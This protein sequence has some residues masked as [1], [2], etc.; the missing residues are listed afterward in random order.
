M[1]GRLSILVI[2]AAL[3][4]GLWYFFAP[5]DTPDVTQSDTDEPVSGAAP[6]VDD[7]ETADT[8][9][10]PAADTAQTKEADADST[11]DRAQVAD[12]DTDVTT[13]AAQAT[14]P[15]TTI[16]AG[17]TQTADSGADSTT[18]VAQTPESGATPPAGDTQTADSGADSTTGVAQTP[19]SGAT[20]PAGDTQTA[21]SEADSTTGVAQT[22]ESGATPPAG[23][24]QTADSVA[25]SSTDAAQ[26][27]ASGATPKAGDTQTA[28]SGADS[29]TD[30]AQTSE[31]DA[32]VASDVAQTAGTGLV[33]PVDASGTPGPG[34]DETGPQ[35][36]AEKVVLAPA[37]EGTIE[38][39]PIA[40][41]DA[42][43]EDETDRPDVLAAVADGIDRL[44]TAIQDRLGI[45]PEEDTDTTLH[46][47]IEYDDTRQDPA[48]AGLVPDEGPETAAVDAAP[49]ADV[50]QTTDTEVA[51]DVAQTAGTGLV[52]EEGPETAAVDATPPADV[53]QTTDT[54]VASDVAQTA[55]TGLVPEEGPE[56]A[57][58]DATP[59]A[60][61]AQ[62]TDTEVASDVAQTAGTGLV[63]PVD[64]AGTPGSGTVGTGPQDTAMEAD[65]SDKR[66]VVLAPAAEGTIERTPIAPVD[67]TPEDETDRPDV[68]VAVADGID[69]LKTAI[70]N[71]LGI[72]PGEDTD[73][74]LRLRIEYDDTKQ[75]PAPTGLGPDE[76]SETADDD[77]APPPDVAPTTDT[78]TELAAGDAA[79]A[80]DL[81]QTTDAGT[82]PP[83]G[84]AQA[85]GSDGTT[86]TTPL[87]TAD[88]GT[89]PPPKV[90][91]TARADASGEETTGAE[92]KE[93][94]ETL[95][96]T[97]PPTIPVDK[98]DH[99]VTQDSVVSLVPEDS[100]ESITV[101]DL[102][103][104]E[105]LTPETPITV[106]REVE[107]IETA[108]P[109]QLIA[110]S[111]GNLDTP[112]R[113]VVTY[114]D[115][116]QIDEQSSTEEDVAEQ[117]E[118][119]RNV[120]TEDTSEQSPTTQNVVTEDTSG[121]SGVEQITVREALARMRT[122]PEK[123]LT[124]IKTVRYFEV[125][126]LRE[127]LD[128]EKD[129]DA[130][131]NVV[132]QPYRIE[133]ATLADLLRLHKTQ[134]PD[135]I[136]YIHTV[137]PT[138]EQGIWGIVHFG[139][140]E[141]FARGMAVRRGEEIETYTV[142]IPKHADE[143][144]DDQSSSFLGRLIDR[145]TKDSYV[146]N[147]RENRMGRNP[148]TIY[149]GQEI[150][151]INFELGELEAIYEHFAGG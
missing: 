79:P 25:D 26:T 31:P 76:G 96:A 102:A 81:A 106:V 108:V 10:E 47:R 24:T 4:V 104:D 110:D 126:T 93:Y 30:I 77:A 34:T 23:D 32:T 46:L 134:S 66:E 69:R 90:D 3:A 115:S 52:P 14:E 112:L 118:T 121:Q 35:A 70:E 53:A 139:L 91:T 19:E 84:S 36:A 29:A 33:P 127:L 105:T 49:P 17:D 142:Q 72:E 103:D 38:R 68:L 42:T 107:Q 5:S 117:R 11:A 22:P 119:T 116:Q 143:R 9:T 65:P 2:A 123:P 141:N 146:Y 39:T 133:A 40:P 87:R 27:T 18:D 94:V 145:K 63:P 147:Y 150:V 86:S 71:R 129:A 60:D 44:K 55:G 57:A 149:P 75:D 151:I 124:I 13:D 62:T 21:D 45:E 100:I 98:A 130:F 89:T 101:G 144:L 8:S 28:D 99:F 137:Q 12:S 1:R 83:T 61:V 56:T 135:T 88:S 114:D 136:S 132:L 125:M 80:P 85:I 58:V 16:Q 78:D 51:S 15:G 67:A 109:E 6:A 120:V 140:I 95:T 59:P 131:L 122:E 64:T 97:T 138:D 50:A 148:D 74:P 43:P 37:T 92:A 54:E 111:G 73:T 113:V 128:S 82:E 7:P 41:A 20:P 48:P